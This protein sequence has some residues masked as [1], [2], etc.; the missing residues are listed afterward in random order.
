MAADAVFGT[1]ELLREIASHIYE[2]TSLSQ[3]CLVNHAFNAAFTPQLYRCL[4]WDEHNI[5]SLSDPGQRRRL[6]QSRNLA[7]ARIFIIE[8]SGVESLL[9]AW[10][11]EHPRKEPRWRHG[12]HWYFT[13][14]E[15]IWT[16]LNDAVVD[17]CQRTPRLQTFASQ[18]LV[19]SRDS[20]VALSSISSLRNISI[21]FHEDNNSIGDVDTDAEEKIRQS[22]GHPGPRFIFS[23]LRRLSLLGLW[24][25][26]RA[27]REQILKIILNSPDLEYLAL[28]ISEEALP[29]PEDEKDEEPYIY[30]WLRREYKEATGR[31]LALKL[32]TKLD[33]GQ[34]VPNAIT[35][36]GWAM[37]GSLAKVYM[38]NEADGPFSQ[39]L[40]AFP[41]LD[42][43]AQRDD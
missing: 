32:S 16:Q 33:Y 27:W 42:I 26:I 14:R 3:L 40:E 15:I 37:P 10:A 23:G 38:W 22:F 13:G 18:D 7:H 19:L 24:G 5:S 6:L 36:E 30:E 25:D 43:G 39:G 4:R 41:M 2:R 12:D 28:S 17:V 35:V 9:S 8:R 31:L 11:R 34:K 1:A 20:V 21:E 29:E